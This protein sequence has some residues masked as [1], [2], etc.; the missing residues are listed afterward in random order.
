M[1]EP[2]EAQYR[3]RTPTSYLVRIGIL[4]CIGVM[5]LGIVGWQFA[6]L[7]HEYRYDAI[8][9]LVVLAIVPIV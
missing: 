2:V 7:T 5:C 4:S 6:T 8:A 1:A 3:V 9:L